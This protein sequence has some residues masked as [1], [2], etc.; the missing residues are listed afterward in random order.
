MGENDFRSTSNFNFYHWSACHCCHFSKKPHFYNLQLT[1]PLEVKCNN[2]NRRRIFLLSRAAL[3]WRSERESKA[4]GV[5]VTIV[6]LWPPFELWLCAVIVALD[7]DGQTTKAFIIEWTTPLQTET[8]HFKKRIWYILQFYKTQLLLLLLCIQLYD[9]Q[10]NSLL[11]L[12]FLTLI[13]KGK[14][15][16]LIH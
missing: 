15:N 14:M 9:T 13:R 12:W 6:K 3:A 2:N 16:Q 5:N 7:G 11:T 8:T 1:V 4:A 10:Y